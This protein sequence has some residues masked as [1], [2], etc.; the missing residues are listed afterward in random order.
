MKNILKLSLVISGFHLLCALLSGIKYLNFCGNPHPF[1]P[2]EDGI[3]L[4]D[5]Y[6]FSDIVCSILSIVFFFLLLR[7]AAANSPL[8]WPFITII[9]GFALGLLVWLM[10]EMLIK[11]YYG[12]TDTVKMLYLVNFIGDIL[13]SAGLIWFG[14]FFEKRSLVRITSYIVPVFIVLSTIISIYFMVPYGFFPQIP[15]LDSL[16]SL[17]HIAYV[18]FFYSFYKYNQSYGRN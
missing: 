15:M 5:C 7:K 18:I 16:T 8:K 14:S 11:D 10:W 6:L 12:V 9:G 1:H 3:S 4:G 2:Q 13:L 17:M